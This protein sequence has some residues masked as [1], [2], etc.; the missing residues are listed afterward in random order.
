VALGRRLRAFE[1]LAGR[2]LGGQR[3]PSVLHPL[4][5]VRNQILSLRATSL[6]RL[7][8][9]GVLYAECG[10]HHNVHAVAHAVQPGGVGLNSIYHV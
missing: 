7:D 1:D 4:I 8:N 3:L 2:V 9:G 5:A 6:G 10:S